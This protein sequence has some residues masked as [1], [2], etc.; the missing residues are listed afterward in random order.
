[1]FSEDASMRFIHR[2]SSVAPLELIMP[3]QSSASSIKTPKSLCFSTSFPR[4][5]VSDS[6]HTLG[7]AGIHVHC[8]L[9]TLVHHPRLHHKHPH[10][11]PAPAT[12]TAPVDEIAVNLAMSTAEVSTHNEIPIM[13]RTP[14]IQIFK[15]IKHA[16]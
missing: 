12:P 7:N 2:E 4:R 6:L 16:S 14:K 9:Y 11:N 15:I 3:H 5:P 1:M 8:T 10:H 13:T